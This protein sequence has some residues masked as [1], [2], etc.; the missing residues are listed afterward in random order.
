MVNLEI[1]VLKKS[2]TAMFSDLVSSTNHT[3]RSM[4]FKHTIKLLHTSVMIIIIIIF[5]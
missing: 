5:L 1:F 4:S 2:N 3:L